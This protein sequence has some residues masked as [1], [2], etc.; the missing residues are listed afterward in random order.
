M[1]IVIALA[2]LIVGLLVGFLIGAR[3]KQIVQKVKVSVSAAF[4][5]RSLFKGQDAA[6]GMDGAENA[7]EGDEAD[8]FEDGKGAE[9]DNSLLENFLQTEEEPGL[10]DHLDTDINPVIMYNIK[11]AK[12]AQKLQHQREMLAA[13]GLS[14][15]DIAL[16]LAGGNAGVGETKPSALAI[17]IAAGARVEA[18]GNVQ[19]A[20]AI[21]KS[22]MRRK[23]RNVNVFLTK[24]LEIDTKMTAPKEQ[25]D[26]GGGRKKSAFDIARDTKLNP[27]GGPV[28]KRSVNATQQ[29]KSARSVFRRDRARIEREQKELNPNL[30]LANIGAEA[31]IARRRGVKGM[32]AG[33]IS[34]EDLAAQLAAEDE[35]PTGAEEGE[36]GDGEDEQLEKGEEGEEGDEELLEA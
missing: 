22:E 14:E 13:E 27:I 1:S 5:L 19:N 23:Q 8:D 28:L 29:A 26:R 2:F 31:S 7:D 16:R 25:R 20:E 10:D 9:D 21:K 12:E 11:K 6:S 15:D 17:M 35:G 3:A 4:S 32:V 36:E 24:T 18:A 34:A 33:G 30:F